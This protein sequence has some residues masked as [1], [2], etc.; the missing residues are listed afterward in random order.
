MLLLW[1]NA[2][3]IG[4]LYEEPTP[5]A[6]CSPHFRQLHKQRLQ[7]R[8]SVYV[9]GFLVHLLRLFNALYAKFILTVPFPFA[10]PWYDRESYTIGRTQAKYFLGETEELCCS[11][12]EIYCVVLLTVLIYFFVQM[13]FSDETAKPLVERQG[14]VFIWIIGLQFAIF[15]VF[16]SWGGSS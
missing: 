12:V 13:A 14:V 15:A 6:S 1:I 7:A 10:G 2:F 16:R 3:A 4:L 9:F 11:L 5:D 8:A